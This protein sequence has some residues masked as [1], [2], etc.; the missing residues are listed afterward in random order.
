MR[1]ERKPPS[2]PT[3]REKGILSEP[4]DLGCIKAL[5]RG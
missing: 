4:L 5:F 2:P 3:V 1:A